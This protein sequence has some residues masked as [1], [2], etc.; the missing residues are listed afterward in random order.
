M[1]SFLL[2]SSFDTC[3]F[4]SC[5]AT[6]YFDEH[7]SAT[8][9]LKL[10]S[11]VINMILLHKSCRLLIYLVRLFHGLGVWM[12]VTTFDLILGFYYHNVALEYYL[13]IK[14]PLFIDCCPLYKCRLMR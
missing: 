13:T 12:K 6:C 3:A 11:L 14:T 4:I 10:A 1:T 5:L 8:C 9:W 2:I 7:I